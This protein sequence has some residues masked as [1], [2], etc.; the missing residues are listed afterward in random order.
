[1]R[2]KA[3]CAF[4]PR[5]AVVAESQSSS[6]KIQYSDDWGTVEEIETFVHGFR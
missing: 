1:M 6:T 2:Q 3:H 4:L 5:F